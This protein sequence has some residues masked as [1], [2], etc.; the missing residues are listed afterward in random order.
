[1]LLEA[2]RLDPDCTDARLMLLDLEGT[3]TAE[4]EIASLRDLVSSAAQRLGPACFETNAGTFWLAHETRPY[5]RARARLAMALAESGR[6]PEAI[7]EHQGMLELCPGDN[8]G[9]RYPLLGLLLTMGEVE[10]AADLFAR[11]PDEAAAT[12]RWGQVLHRFLAGDELGARRALKDAREANGEVEGFL[13][14]RRSLPREGPDSYTLGGPD[15]AI[16]SARDLG[17]AWRRHP[18]AVVWLRAIA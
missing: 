13:A 17:E 4:E 16:M 3:D 2:V 6:E 1:M 9:L 7:A 11:Y 12:F 14:A 18:E 5:M 8:L 10:A 15:E